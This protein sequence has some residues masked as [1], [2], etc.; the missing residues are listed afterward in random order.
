MPR[1]TV[2]SGS[3]PRIFFERSGG[4]MK[5]VLIKNAY[6]LEDDGTEA[7]VEIFVVSGLIRWVSMQ[8]FVHKPPAKEIPVFDAR[9]WSVWPGVID[10][11]VHGRYPPGRRKETPHSLRASAFAGGVTY[12]GLMPNTD[13]AIVDQRTLARV[14]D[15]MSD[16]GLPVMVH[17]GAV[18]RNLSVLKALART[19]GV[20]ALKVYRAKTTG[21]LLVDDD[22]VFRKILKIASDEDVAVMVHAEHQDVLDREGREHRAE[23]EGCAASCHGSMRSPKAEVLGVRRDIGIYRKGGYRCKLVFAHL[24]V[25][26]SLELVRLAKGDGLPVFAEVTPHH[27]LLNDHLLARPDG[28]RFQVN[29]PLRSPDE[30]A[31]LHSGLVNGLVDYI[32]SDHAPHTPSE[33]L[34]PFG[35]APSGFAGIETLLPALLDQRANGVLSASTVRALTSGNAAS[36]F[37][38]SDRGV[39]AF[40][41]RADFVFVDH[42][43]SWMVHTE[44]LHSKARDSPFEGVPFCGARIMATM[45]AGETVYERKET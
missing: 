10:P 13:P 21:K 34:K 4:V 5:S 17:V 38:L 37:G 22:A 40:G 6:L 15:R 41:K 14:Q 32:G 29:P 28:T 25:W 31:L 43:A 45:V 35:Q 3:L 8:D 44:G 2:A 39:I 24:S 11:H 16:I 36:I 12:S 18:E 23:H 42:H 33:K 30:R 19:K 9:G 26:R 27:L 20:R 7:P 1:D